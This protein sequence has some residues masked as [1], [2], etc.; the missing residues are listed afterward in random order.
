MRGQ[1][2]MEFEIRTETG[3]L[4]EEIGREATHVCARIDPL[5][6]RKKS[7]IILSMPFFLSR[8]YEKC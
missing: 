7:R 8:K 6:V 4:R 2:E 1:I 3:D 5:K